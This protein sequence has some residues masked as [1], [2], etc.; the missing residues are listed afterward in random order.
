MRI[1]YVFSCTYIHFMEIER[2]E[3]CGKYCSWDMVVGRI[4]D[5]V[6][7]KIINFSHKWKKNVASVVK[8]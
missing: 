5:S 7:D 3:I 8:Y 6:F 1:R 4:T 2:T